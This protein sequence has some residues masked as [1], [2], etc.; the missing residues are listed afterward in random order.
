MLD[1]PSSGGFIHRI[2]GDPAY[3]AA[4]G[5]DFT[6]ASPMI[7]AGELTPPILGTLRHRCDSCH[8]DE[9]NVFTFRMMQI[10]GRPTFTVRQL[11]PAE[12]HR[13]S[14]V[15]EKKMERQDFKSLSLGR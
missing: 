3:L 14:Y 10:P 5:N 9:A 7:G 4:A 2:A 13:A 11:R 15:A 6:F 8:G 1:E 12:D